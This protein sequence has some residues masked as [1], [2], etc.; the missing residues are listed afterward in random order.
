MKI[1]VI[2]GHTRNIGKT[3]VAAN[4]IR[5]FPAFNWTAVKI[6]QYG[7]GVCSHDGKPCGCA[8]TGHPFALSEERNTEGRTDS[9][10]FLAAGAR[11]SLWLRVRQ[12]QLALAVP[13]L[14]K[15]LQQSKSIIVESNSILEFLT[16]LLYLAI[17]DSSKPDFKPSA[18]KFLER[19]DALL[20]VRPALAPDVWPGIDFPSV[21]QKPEFPVPPPDYANLDLFRFVQQK[22]SSGGL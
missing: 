6:T 19:A 1:I 2:G 17:L 18:R 4:L 15:A 11:R 16:P 20:P 22:L 5:A 14:K 13:V 21:S 7:H 8:P 3:S 10:R 12:G 9:S